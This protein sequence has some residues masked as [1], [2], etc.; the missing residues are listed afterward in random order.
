[1]GLF[2]RPAEAIETNYY[3]AC[4]VQHQKERQIQAKLEK[5][6]L[7]FAREVCLSPKI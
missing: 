1:M 3:Q 7:N 4:V 6:P 5:S 2:I